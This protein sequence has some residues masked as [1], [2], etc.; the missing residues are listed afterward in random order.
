MLQGDKLLGSRRRFYVSG[1]RDLANMGVLK[2]LARSFNTLAGELMLSP[3]RVQQLPGMLRAAAFRSL[4]GP[5][6][7]P[8]SDQCASADADAGHMTR[9][10]ASHLFGH[11]AL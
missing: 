10:V 2:R 4:P 7:A 8:L 6:V 5:A 1:L 11:P 3:A 9:R